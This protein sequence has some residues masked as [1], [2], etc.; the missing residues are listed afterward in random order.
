MGPYRHQ[1]PNHHLRMLTGHPD[2]AAN[3][4]NTP[5]PLLEAPFQVRFHAYVLN[6]W[7]A[8]QR[9]QGSE[10]FELGGFLDTS[11]SH[12][13]GEQS[14]IFSNKIWEVKPPRFLERPLRTG[15]FL[16]P[17]QPWRIHK[18]CGARS[19]RSISAMCHVLARY[20]ASITRS[21]VVPSR[22]DA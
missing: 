3:N 7:T 6:V 13:S 10:Y 8:R 20:S 1:Q 16:H 18:R 14:Y 15:F 4:S 21:C 11:A 5:P 17:S 2:E 19:L 22:C 9:F 12:V